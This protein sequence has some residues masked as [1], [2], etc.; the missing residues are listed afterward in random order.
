M[1]GFDLLF[2]FRFNYFKCGFI[3]GN[4]SSFFF[5]RWRFFY[6][7]DCHLQFTHAVL[8]GVDDVLDYFAFCWVGGVGHGKQPISNFF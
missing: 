7:S 1:V 2:S 4:E 3:V 5:R 6:H 8:V